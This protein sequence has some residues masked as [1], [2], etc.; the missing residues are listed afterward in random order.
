L[1]SEMGGAMGKASEPILRFAPSPNG[2][3]H[4]GH[5]FSA[6]FTADAARRLGG[7]MLVRIE[8]IDLD[9]SREEFTRAIF[10]DLHWLGLEWEEPV[11]VQSAHFADYV[12]AAGRLAALGLT[13]PCFCTRSEIRQAADDRTDP[14]GAPLYPGTCRRLSADER[15]ARIAAGELHAL[16]LDIAAA[17]A[18]TGPLE[19][20]ELGRNL[21]GSRNVAAHPEPWGDVV[22]VRKQT[23]TSY[24][25][26]VVVDDALQGV[27]HVTRGRDLF[28][29]TAIHRLLQAL[30]GLPAPAWCHH[31]LIVDA[32]MHKLAK[33]AG[34]VSLRDLREAGWTA[35]E[36]RRRLGF[37]RP[38]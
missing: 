31:R 13:Y 17:A 28:E 3:L 25:L 1:L 35:A 16:R 7:R 34:S 37:D 33:S 21:E 6:L 24:H 18:R 5:A 12:A 4:L 29:A 14:E 10:D 38:G 2:Y 9:R 30:L 19:W 27:T 26:S 11:R 32:D 22:V 8:D 20:R 36:V 15:A 23:P